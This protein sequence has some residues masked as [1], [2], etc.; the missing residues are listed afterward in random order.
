MTTKRQKRRRQTS[1]IEIHSLPVAFDLLVFLPPY[2]KPT[3]TFRVFV[4]GPF[5]PWPPNQ[6]RFLDWTRLLNDSGATWEW[7]KTPQNEKTK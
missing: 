6:S 3:G 1:K 4:L 7:K 2:Q 5:C